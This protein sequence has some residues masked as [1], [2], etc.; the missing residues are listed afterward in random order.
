ML[1]N[2][3]FHSVRGARELAGEALMDRV[4]DDT[5]AVSP[6]L[7]GAIRAALEAQTGVRERRD[8]LR[9]AVLSG[10]VDAVVRCARIYLGI[11]PRKRGT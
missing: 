9:K 10:D 11:E 3:E 6:E 4:S 2:G 8:A 7:V 1:R 5:A